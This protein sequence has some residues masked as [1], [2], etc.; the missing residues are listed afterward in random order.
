MKNLF[1]NKKSIKI[2]KYENTK[3]TQKTNRRI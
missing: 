1:K 3:K 2:E